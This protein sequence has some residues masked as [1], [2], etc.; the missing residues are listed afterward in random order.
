MLHIGRNVISLVLSRILSG[1]VLFLIYTQLYNYLG[2]EASGHFGL[3]SFYLTVFGFFVDLGLPH[4]IIKKMSEDDSHIGKYLS[5]Y[6]WLQLVLAG[7]FML[8]MDG[9]VYFADYPQ[10]VKNALY[11][12]SLGL[13]ASSMSLPFRAVVVAKQK[14]TVNAKVNFLNAL[15]NGLMIVAAIVFRQNVFFLAFISVTVG[16]VNLFIYAYV[17]HR[18]FVPFKW[19][20]DS[21]FIKQLLAWNKPFMFLTIFSVYNKIDGL[22]LPHLRNFVETGYYAAAYRFWDALAAFPGLLGISLYPFFAHALSKGMKDSVKAGLETYT[23]YMIAVAV[24]MS[25]GAFLLADEITLQFLKEE[26]LPASQA[27]WILIVAVSI[28]FIYTPANSL[29]ISQLPKTATKVTGFTLLFNLTTNLIFIPKYG[30]VAAAATTALSE[31][32]QTIGYT[33]LIKKRI[34]DFSFFSHFAKP[35]ASAAAM[36]VV[37][38]LFQDRNLLMV[39]AGGGAIYAGS[40]VALKFFNQSDLALLKAALNFKKELDPESTQTL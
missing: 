1:V 5:N 13:L 27:V 39:I 2:A 30:F 19:E 24:P 22:M 18:K 29:I 20:V 21:V 33:Y 40:M 32:I 11:I 28:L 9:F 14:L 17:V 16:V 4:L 8:I 3:L 6:F 26:F 36:G 35:V 31:L 10:H 12:A 38:Y 23:R 34:V 25:V 37:V 15:I 7:L